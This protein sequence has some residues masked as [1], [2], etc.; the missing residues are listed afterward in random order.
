MKVRLITIADIRRIGDMVK[1]RDFLYYATATVAAGA[2]GTA[3]FG[4][5]N[6]LAPAADQR[7][8]TRI[9]ID[10]SD[11]QE[12][13]QLTIRYRGKPL[14]LRHRTQEEII[15]ARA[16]PLDDLLDIY[17][18]YETK[19]TRQ[20]VTDATDQNRSVDPEGR[21]VLLVGLC[22]HLG[23][24]PLGD[25][26]GDFD[27]WFCPCHGAHFDASGR[28]RK[29]PA[30]YN[31][32]IPVYSWDGET[33]ITLSDEDALAPLNEAELDKVLYGQTTDAE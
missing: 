13:Q 6:A 10:F 11:L 14:F 32:T 31:M 24:V 2:T 1:K 27:G 12:G 22:T 20:S 33:T 29:G 8:D 25:R 3:I 19:R 28:V 5:G 26:S 17:N 23:C 18:R 21:Y 4:L 30:P 9:R 7:N 16:T 15:E